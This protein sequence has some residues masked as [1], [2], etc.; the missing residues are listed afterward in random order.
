MHKIFRDY[1]TE[2]EKYC[3][4]NGLDSNK[5]FHSPKC[6]SDEMVFIPYFDPNRTNVHG[7]WIDKPAPVALGIYK[8]DSGLRFEQTEYTKQYLSK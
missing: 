2:I 4:K 8:T 3:E 6:G 5:V 7:P 1:Q